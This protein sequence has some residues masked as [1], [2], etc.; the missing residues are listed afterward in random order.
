[1]PS[2]ASWNFSAM[3]HQVVAF[4]DGVLEGGGGGGGV[5]DGGRERLGGGGGGGGGVGGGVGDGRGGGVR[6]EQVADGFARSDQ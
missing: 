2:S 6:R 1:M 5:G 4:E 3:T